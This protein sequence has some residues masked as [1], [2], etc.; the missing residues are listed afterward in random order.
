[1]TINANRL[2]VLKAMAEAD[3]RDAYLVNRA[4]LIALLNELDETRELLEQINRLH[5]E[6]K[7]ALADEVLRSGAAR[8]DL[9]AAKLRADGGQRLAAALIARGWEGDYNECV[10]CESQGIT[11][12]DDPANHEPDCPLVPFLKL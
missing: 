9:A 6:A 2:R 11:R 3:S 5:T 8:V 4:E 1:M 12:F 7:R 10:V